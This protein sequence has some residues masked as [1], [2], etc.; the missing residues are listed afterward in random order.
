MKL[1]GAL[2]F[3]TYEKRR[4]DFGRWMLRDYPIQEQD[5][6]KSN[7]FSRY[8]ISSLIKLD[9]SLGFPREVDLVFNTHK[10]NN[11]SLF[12]IEPSKTSEYPSSSWVLDKRGN[13]H[14]KFIVSSPVFLLATKE[15]FENFELATPSLI[16][17]GLFIVGYTSKEILSAVGRH[18]RSEKK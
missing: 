11:F 10:D 3:T 6:F 9:S 16:H 4:G 1:K 12:V 17:Y 5:L 14:I 15:S 13:Q 18:T 2:G 7:D 8:K